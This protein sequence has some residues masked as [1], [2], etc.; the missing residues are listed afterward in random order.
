MYKY[1]LVLHFLRVKSQRFL[2]SVMVP[3]NTVAVQLVH[4]DDSNTR[5]SGHK[6][7]QKATVTIGSSK[8]IEHIRPVNYYTRENGG[9]IVVRFFLT[10]F[11][12]MSYNSIHITPN[13][14]LPTHPMNYAVSCF[15]LTKKTRSLHWHFKMRFKLRRPCAGSIQN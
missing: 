1:S 14:H 15:T 6:Q 8:G 4:F 10:M 13:D 7:R 3:W 9:P 5:V 11:P 12:T 2:S